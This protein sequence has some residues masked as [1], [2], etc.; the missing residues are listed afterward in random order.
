MPVFCTCSL[1]PGSS[2]AVFIKGLL[3]RLATSFVSLQNRQ[4]IIMDVV[5]LPLIFHGN[6]SPAIFSA[7]ISSTDAFDIICGDVDLLL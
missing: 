2:R 1:P 4:Y 7:K 5:D 6:S 3:C